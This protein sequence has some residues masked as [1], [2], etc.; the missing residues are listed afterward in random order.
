M[1][2]ETISCELQCYP[3]EPHSTPECTNVVNERGSHNTAGAARDQHLSWNNP[4]SLRSNCQGRTKM[5]L[6][7]IVTGYSGILSSLCNSG[8]S[9]VKASE[10]LQNRI[11]R[12]C[13]CSCATK[14]RDLETPAFVTSRV[15]GFNVD[16][17]HPNP[18]DRL[19]YR[20]RSVVRIQSRQA[21]LLAGKRL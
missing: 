15:R 11:C 5:A 18:P 3:T 13:I 20:G 6:P 1:P 21:C 17:P 14:L 4:P 9:C 10:V 2:H 16:K 8:F 12:N 19:C 7:L